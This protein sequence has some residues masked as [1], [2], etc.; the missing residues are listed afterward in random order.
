[1]IAPV[2]HSSTHFLQSLHLFTSMYAKKSVT[3]IAS[4]GQ[5][6]VHFPQPM[7][8]AEQAL[9]ATAPLSLLEQPTYI[10]KSFL[11][12]FLISIKCC[13]QAFAHC[14]QAVHK[15]VVTAGIF[16]SGL[17]FMAPNWQADSQS[18]RPKHPKEQP[19]SPA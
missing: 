2:G 10:L 7:Q 4:L 15:L 5:T 6:F 16:V 19:V 17:T 12:V 13:G 14:P 18:P 11:L 3:V 8:A 1:M 9:R